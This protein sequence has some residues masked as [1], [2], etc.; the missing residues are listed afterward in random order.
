MMRHMTIIIAAV[1]SIIAASSAHALQD[2]GKHG[3]PEA[4]PTVY[5]VVS[6]GGGGGSGLQPN[7]Y[8]RR[9]GCLNPMGCPP[10]GDPFHRVR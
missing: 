7:P 3:R 6:G 10:K 8:M 2:S 5:H 1:G 4:P 9:Y